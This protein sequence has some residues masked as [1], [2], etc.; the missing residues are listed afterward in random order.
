MKRLS[1][2]K[3]IRIWNKKCREKIRDERRLYYIPA[4]SLDNI[5]QNDLDARYPDRGGRRSEHTPD[6]ND[7]GMDPHGG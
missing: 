1:L 2:W 6:D 3:R 5:T 7:G 4:T